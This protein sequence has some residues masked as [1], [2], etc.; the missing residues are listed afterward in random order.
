MLVTSIFSF[1]HNVFKSLLPRT[2][3]VGIVY[4]AYKVFYLYV[5]IIFAEEDLNMF[6][7]WFAFLKGLKK[8]TFWE[9]EKMLFTSIFSFS[10]NVFKS[11]H[12]NS[13]LCGNGLIHQ[14]KGLSLLR[15]W[16]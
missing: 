6:Q 8:K 13:A 2:F 7:M 3:Y 16:V 4:M 15:N 12:L 1:S 10:Y 11:L 5:W 9:K 14:R